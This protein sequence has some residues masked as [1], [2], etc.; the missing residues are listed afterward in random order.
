MSLTGTLSYRTVES[1][2][3]CATEHSGPEPPGINVCPYRQASDS[4]PHSQCNAIL[5]LPLL[6][7]LLRLPPSTGGCML[8]DPGPCYTALPQTVVDFLK[9]LLR[10]HA[11][12]RKPCGPC[13]VIYNDLG[14][15]E[16][17]GTLVLCSCH[18]HAA[19][20][21]LSPEASCRLAPPGTTDPCMFD[22]TPDYRWGSAR[23][24]TAAK[25]FSTYYCQNWRIP[26]RTRSNH[27]PLRS[28][29]N[30][31]ALM[32]QHGLPQVLPDPEAQ[33]TCSPP[34]KNWRFQKHGK[35]LSPWMLASQMRGRR[36]AGA[37][38]PPP[39]AAKK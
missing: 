26:D 21:S 11:G 33:P 32:G 4:A 36:F 7:L 24:G 29:R 13:I 15:Q 20:G 2:S 5:P 9:I 39:L 16:A 14:S 25:V 28:R 3:G 10:L 22:E 12:F 17:R 18:E 1:S 30:P 37:G 6:V 27:Y 8:V 23:F 38:S 31:L 35:T 19:A 34:R